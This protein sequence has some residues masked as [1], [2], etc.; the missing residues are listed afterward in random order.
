MR[1][2]T[3]ILAILA[4][5]V[6]SV[7]ACNYNA[8]AENKIFSGKSDFNIAS[9][10]GKIGK[11]SRDAKN[12][13]ENHEKYVNTSDAPKKLAAF[14]YRKMKYAV[15]LLADLGEDEDD[16]KFIKIAQKLHDSEPD[17]NLILIDDD[18]GLKQY[19]AFMREV[20][21]LGSNATR[22]NR[23]PKAWAEEHILGNV[24]A[25]GENNSRKWFLM[26]GYIH[27][28]KIAELK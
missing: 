22:K 25:E 6:S 2:K 23:F 4:M 11:S 13:D 3:A 14:T 10:N 7:A 12:A 15:Y 19:V 9:T 17:T 1:Y 18:S 20:E 27:S 26:L 21:Q 5:S 28:E 8:N 16:V 24:G